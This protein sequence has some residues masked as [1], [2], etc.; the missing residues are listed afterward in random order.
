V[1]GRAFVR[2]TNL[3]NAAIKA[4]CPAF[5]DCGPCP[6]GTNITFDE[7][8]AIRPGAFTDNEQ[9]PADRLRPSRAGGRHARRREVRGAAEGRPLPRQ[10]H[11]ADGRTRRSRVLQGLTLANDW[12]VSKVE[13]FPGRED[14]SATITCNLPAAGSSSPAVACHMVSDRGGA[15]EFVVAPIIKGR[16]STSPF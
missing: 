6:S 5:L 15:N 7:V 12:V 3:D 14:G 8:N 2:I 1:L 10:V 4:D 9:S 13:T 16:K 11:R